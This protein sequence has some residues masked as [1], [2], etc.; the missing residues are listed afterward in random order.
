MPLNTGLDPIAIRAD[1]A[2]GMSIAQLAQKY[3]C[4]TSTISWHLQSDHGRR[5]GL[6]LDGSAI[7]Q[8]YKSGMTM[9]ELMAKYNCSRGGIRNRLRAL[10][11]NGQAPAVPDSVSGNGTAATAAEAATA[12]VNGN[13]KS[14]G[15]ATSTTEEEVSASVSNPQKVAQLPNSKS[16]GHTLE[17]TDQIEELITDWWKRL[18]LVERIRIVLDSTRWGLGHPVMGPKAVEIA[19]KWVVTTH[20]LPAERLP[21]KNLPMGQP[22]APLPVPG[23]C[24]RLDGAAPGLR[25]LKGFFAWLADRWRIQ[26]SC[27]WQF[28]PNARGSIGMRATP[29]RIGKNTASRILN[30]KR[31]SSINPSS[32]GPTRSIH[33]SMRTVISPS[34]TP[35]K[36]GCCS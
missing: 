13:G 20:F 29:V 11:R 27:T 15:P 18:P 7:C 36:I 2:A 8:D 16:N 10:K 14:P 17:D 30:A 5:N 35:I 1:R 22:A 28:G 33:N 25:D 32:C 34:V 23:H 9:R 21:R 12:K 4:A 31:F 24:L 26:W 19:L 3:D 6:E